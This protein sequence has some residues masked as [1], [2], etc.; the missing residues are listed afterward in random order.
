MEDKETDQMSY[1][2]LAA[3]LDYMLRLLERILKLNS[4]GKSKCIAD[5]IEDLLR[6]YHRI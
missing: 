2:D 5:E 6:A 1:N 3:E 4:M